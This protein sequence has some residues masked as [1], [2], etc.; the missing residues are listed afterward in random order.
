M[1]ETSGR[2]VFLDGRQL[3]SR[4]TAHFDAASKAAAS[5]RRLR[6]QL[7][8]NY[9]EPDSDDIGPLAFYKKGEPSRPYNETDY[10][11]WLVGNRVVLETFNGVQGQDGKGWFRSVT[12]FD[13]VTG[14]YV[15][16]R[17]T[18]KGESVISSNV[19]TEVHDRT[20]MPGVYIQQL[21]ENLAAV[22]LANPEFPAKRADR[23]VQIHFK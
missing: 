2:N 9:H 16:I 3:T 15:L 18:E 7:A 10:L 4:E 23:P 14:E 8:V 17:N 13:A 20:N 11:L 21:A 12:D 1:A 6:S 19:F 5:V 22:A